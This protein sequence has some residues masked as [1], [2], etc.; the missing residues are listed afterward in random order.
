M[1]NVMKFTNLQLKLLS[2]F[3]A[4]MAVVWFGATI[5]SSTSVFIGI[6]SL[7]TGFLSLFIGMIII[8]E[9]YEK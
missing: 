8:K 3:F 6:R 1:K 7:F 4:N 9:V 5:I 2:D